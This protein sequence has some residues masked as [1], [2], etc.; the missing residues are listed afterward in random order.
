[1]RVADRDNELTH[2]QLVGVAQLRW[3]KLA[4]VSADDREV[5]EGI[6]AHDVEPQLAPVVEGGAPARAPLSHHVGRRQQ[7][8]IS[9]DR[10]AAT[11]AYGHR[12][13][14]GRAH[15][16]QARNCRRQPPRHLG[17]RSRV[18][19]ERLIAGAFARR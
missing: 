4:L 16:T 2:A 5:G 19:V 15:H 8:A 1:M 12:A 18:R 14:A 10:H 7:K 3:R 6:R 17:D 9:R 11:R 13:T